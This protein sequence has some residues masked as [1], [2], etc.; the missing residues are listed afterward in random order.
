ML[1]LVRTTTRTARQRIRAPDI[2]C[3]HWRYPD[4]ARHY[5]PASALSNRES[6]GVPVLEDDF[7]FMEGSD[8]EEEKDVQYDSTRR[9]RP[10]S[11]SHYTTDASSPKWTYLYQ[12]DQNFLPLSKG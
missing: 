3:S 5:R 2:G 7:D 12:I 4:S 9:P 6:S 8:I 11:D 1:S 10:V